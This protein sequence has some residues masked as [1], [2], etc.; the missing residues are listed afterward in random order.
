MSKSAY[1]GGSLSG[2]SDVL[3]GSGALAFPIHVGTDRAGDS[4]FRAANRRVRASLGH[5]HSQHL[6]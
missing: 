6:P 2:V 3:H 4:G 1:E 5:A